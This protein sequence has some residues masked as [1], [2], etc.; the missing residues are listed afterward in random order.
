MWMLDWH[1][2]RGGCGSRKGI[3]W[4]IFCMPGNQG[5]ATHRLKSAEQGE[6]R[7]WA[8][9]C[10]GDTLPDPLRCLR[11]GCFKSWAAR[12]T[13][14]GCA[15]KEGPRVPGV[16]VPL[17]G[18]VAWF[19]FSC[20]LSHSP[21]LPQSRMPVRKSGSWKVHQYEDL[22]EKNP[23]SFHSTEILCSQII[24]GIKLLWR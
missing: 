18:H 2:H 11:G 24:Y 10:P 3:F 9:T 15:A 19:L 16:L 21:S 12:R 23:C 8:G 17:A 7:L 1:Q 20:F 4:A 14:A 13:C 5:T 22:T 6:D